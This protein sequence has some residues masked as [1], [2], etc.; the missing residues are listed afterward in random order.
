MLF[1]AACVFTKQVGLALAVLNLLVAA[2]AGSRR[3]GDVMKGFLLFAI[4]AA[5]W[6]VWQ[7]LLPSSD[8]HYLGHLRLSTLVANAGRCRV[9]VKY[10][11]A[12]LTRTDL[13]GFL[14]YV[15]A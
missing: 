6:L 14:W 7:Y 15:G 1:T 12:T 8:E 11:I 9:I 4:L 2:S 10:L 3:N 13:F 5:P